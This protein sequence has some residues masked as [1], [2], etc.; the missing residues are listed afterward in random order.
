MT[1][2]PISYTVAQKKQKEKPEFCLLHLRQYFPMGKAEMPTLTFL[3]M[4]K[5]QFFSR[6]TYIAL[7]SSWEQWQDFKK[8]PHQGL[9]FRG[10]Q[11]PPVPVDL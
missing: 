4:M 6:Q 7:S 1:Y 3:E 11:H 5:S 2:F 10:P 8:T 9:L